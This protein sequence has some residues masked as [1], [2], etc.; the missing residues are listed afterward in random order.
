MLQLSVIFLLEDGD[1]PGKGLGKEDGHLEMTVRPKGPELW[2]VEILPVVKLYHICLDNHEEESAESPM[3]PPSD[4]F[5]LDDFPF[6]VF[7]G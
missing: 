5:I 6:H 7:D 3:S 4:V 1:G 2:M